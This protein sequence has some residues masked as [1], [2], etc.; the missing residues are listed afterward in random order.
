MAELTIDMTYAEALFQA[1]C[2]E[3]IEKKVLEDAQDLMKIIKDNPDLGAFIKS[4]A[5]AAAEKKEVLCSIFEANIAQ[6]LMNFI[7]I[8]IDKGRIMHLDRMVRAYEQLYNSK[9]GAVTGVIY[10]VE[11][12]SE[13]RI[14]RF[15]EETSKLIG[16]NILLENMIDKSLIG[17][18]KIMVDGRVIDASI[19]SR[20][21]KLASEIRL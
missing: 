5:I 4:P 14:K 12:L 11:P 16:E 10:S 2:E 21:D 6:E 13:D 8:L 1:A 17:G 3:N 7:C 15:Q 18:V 9:D 20:F 19:K